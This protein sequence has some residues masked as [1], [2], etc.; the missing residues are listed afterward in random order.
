[1]GWENSLKPPQN[2]SA[3]LQLLD[4]LKS[5]GP[6]G[7]ID[8]PAVMPAAAPEKVVENTLPFPI[9]VVNVDD[10]E[11]VCKFMLAFHVGFKNASRC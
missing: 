4:V 8:A 3:R 9:D 10:S 5:N 11:K 1:V 7:H 6:S 2:L